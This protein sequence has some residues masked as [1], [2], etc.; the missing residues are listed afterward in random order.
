MRCF[1]VLALSLIAQASFS[2]GALAADVWR[3][4][5]VEAKSDAGFAFMAADHG[6]GQKLGLDLQT[7]QF[8]GDAIAM[9]ALIAGDVDSYE[10]SPGSP[11]IAASHGADVKVVGCYWPGLNYDIIAKKSVGGIHDLTGKIFAISSP[12]ALPDLFARAVLQTAKIAPTSVSFVAM[13]SDADRFRSVSA[14]I[15][16]A[17]AVSSEFEPILDKAGL[18]V[19]ARAHDLAPNFLRF[20]IYMTGQTLAQRPDDAAKFLASEIMAIRY[21][22]SHVD[23]TVALTRSITH[24]KPDDPRPSFIAHEA[25]TD[26]LVD[27]NI[28]IPL[29]KLA[30]MQDLF[31]Q[32]G[33]LQTKV[34]L[35]KFVD[36][37]IRNK[38][39]QIAGSA[40]K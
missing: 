17:A 2:S 39:L 40:A 25:V 35:S 18:K 34:D 4:G 1:A 31:I 7:E 23:E 10:G 38:A 22:V 26:H 36:T 8:K 3:H 37:D 19:V 28:P 12:G 30:W 24:A 21:A 15:V 14:G 27:P 29:A 20:C 32:T 16:D 9:K 33:N 11:L 6:F 13:G 5:M